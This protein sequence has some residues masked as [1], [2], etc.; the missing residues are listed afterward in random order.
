VQRGGG[1]GGGQLEEPCA[2]RA[3]LQGSRRASAS[4]FCRCNAA[5]RRPEAACAQPLRGSRA[6]AEGRLHELSDWEVGVFIR[7]QAARGW[8][9][10]SRARRTV[11]CLF[12]LYSQVLHIRQMSQPTT[13]PRLRSACWWWSSGVPR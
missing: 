6:W 10:Q 9:H 2:G 3:G 11:T 12:D 1:G 4:L 8:P 7:H 13:Q 5:W